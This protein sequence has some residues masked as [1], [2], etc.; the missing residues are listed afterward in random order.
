MAEG[1]TGSLAQLPLSDIL[2]ML[3]AGGQSG[4]LELS[5]N[6]GRG[7]VYLRKGAIVHAAAGLKTGE[8]A[9]S[10]LLA[11][12][13]GAFRFQ[14]QVL[15]PESTI[16]KP[17]D[18][19][20]SD[21]AR[22]A[23]EREALHRVIPSADSVP[24]LSQ[25]APAHGIMLQPH[26]WQIIARI[27]SHDS[28]SEIAGNLRTEELILMQS[29]VPLVNAGLVLLDSVVKAA[30]IRQT[31]GPHFW[32]TL[33]TAVANAMGPLAEIIIDDAIADMNTTR[34]TFPREQVSALAERIS[35]E[36]RDIDKRVAF[37]QTILGLLR[38][39]GLAA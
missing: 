38:S 8:A 37:Q 11:W 26:E 20:L 29:L 36:I 16:D 25:E 2:T 33:T 14:P 19:L 3:G 7:D 17:L 39:T 35:A 24:R 4:R 18:Q 32:A 5:S 12:P 34:D 1:L 27:N 10:E 22:D 13:G 31:V 6:A 30:P 15:S 28:I 23:T 21:S 9:L